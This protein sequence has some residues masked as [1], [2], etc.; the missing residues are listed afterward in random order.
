M[1]QQIAFLAQHAL[2]VLEHG[3]RYT[4]RPVNARLALFTDETATIPRSRVEI[5]P[6][7]RTDDGAE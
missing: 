7:E 3:V 5:G 1:L 2:P 6:F 4:V